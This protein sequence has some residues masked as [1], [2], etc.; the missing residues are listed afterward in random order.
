M[1]EPPIARTLGLDPRRL[2]AEVFQRLDAR[3]GI[4]RNRR[5]R[6]DLDWE[7]FGKPGRDPATFGAVAGAIA[8]DADWIPHLTIAQLNDHWDQVVGAAIARH[9]VVDSYDETDHTLVIRTESQNWATQLTY[10]IPQLT[11]AIAERLKGLEVERIVVTGPRAGSSR[12]AWV[13]SRKRR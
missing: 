4:I 2:P 11:S 5:V 6:A 12:R 10:L 9:S 13:P 7:S 8:L 1:P 3:A